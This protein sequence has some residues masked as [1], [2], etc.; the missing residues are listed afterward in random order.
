[1]LAVGEQP[2]DDRDGGVDVVL[3]RPGHGRSQVV[4]LRVDQR[5][6]HRCAR[7]PKN[8]SLRLSEHPRE[9][10]CVQVRHRVGVRAMAEPARP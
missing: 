7:G 5:G 9:E 2:A 4:E 6:R 8:A 3:R 1:M 10:L